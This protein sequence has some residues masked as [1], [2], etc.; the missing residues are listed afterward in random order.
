MPESVYDLI[1]GFYRAIIGHFADVDTGHCG[2]EQA[3][4]E[5]AAKIEKNRDLIENSMIHLMTMISSLSAFKGDRTMVEGIVSI[6]NLLPGYMPAGVVKTCVWWLGY[7]TDIDGRDIGT[8]AL[9]DMLNEHGP[10]C[11]WSRV[12]V[13]DSFFPALTIDSVSSSRNAQLA[14]V[15]AIPYR[16]SE[17]EEDWED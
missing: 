8:E 11:P 10:A 4:I 14:K 6:L 17:P 13:E 7:S 16:F 3:R 5:W 2:N 1:W 9:L 12:D 15:Q